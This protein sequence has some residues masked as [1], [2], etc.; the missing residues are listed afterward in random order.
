MPAANGPFGL[1]C[2]NPHQRA[3]VLAALFLCLGFFAGRESHAGCAR[4]TSAEPIRVE[5]VFDGDTLLLADGTRVRLAGVDT[6]ELDHAGGAHQPDAENAR[7]LLRRLIGK[8]GD[9]VRLRPA[10]SGRDH[11][12]RLLAHVY[13]EAGVSIQQSLL[14]AGLAAAYVRP[15]N[16]LN[17]RCYRAAERLA[18]DRGRAIWRRL[19]LSAAA[20]SDEA[21]GF[22]V[23]SGQVQKTRQ[24]RKSVWLDLE[25]TVSVR[26]ARA[27]LAGF[28]LAYAS[29]PPGSR[30][31]VRGW[32]HAYRGR[33]RIRVR[34]PDDLTRL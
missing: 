20:L 21:N 25:G 28:P 13:D 19:P 7:N 4:F 11:Y 6:P 16:L 31:E 22:V 32:L 30:V 34:H 26:I 33:L 27:D 15:P 5:R 10:E 18:R 17:R 2:G 9:R 1:R 29:L 24:S 14:E 12:G 3:P 23:L 8:S